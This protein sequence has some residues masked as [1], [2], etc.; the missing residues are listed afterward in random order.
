MAAGIVALAAFAALAGRSL[1]TPRVHPPLPSTVSEANE[2]FSRAMLFLGTQQDLP[3]A[4]QLLEKALALDPAFA[5]ARAWYGF[6]HVLLIDSGLSNDTSWL[7][8]AEAELRQALAD[9]PNSARA[10][11]SLAMVYLYQGRKEL[12]PQEARKAMELDPNER[13]GPGMLAMYHQWNGEYEQGQ[14]LLKALVAADP[15]FVP[16]RANVGE[17]LRQMGD[18]AGS[19]REQQKILEQDPNSMFALGFLALAHMTQGNIAGSHEALTKARALEPQN[20]QVQ[21]LWALQLALEGHRTEAL[22]AMTGDVLKYG[23]LIVVTSNI[24]EFY[25]VLDDK[26]KAL[27]W[28]DRAVRAGDERASWFERDPLLAN[29]RQEPR[30]REIVDGIRY[31]QE[32]RRGAHDAPPPGRVRASDV[33]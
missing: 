5:H 19:I 20:Y 4:R 25:A 16:A 15:L 22:Q 8:K 32:R 12:T 29:L 3:R 28:L 14:A 26:A 23:E 2:Y 9:D 24:A 18:P 7:Y 6:T 21:A 1:W 27:E 10:H 13:D 30:F 31:R 33:T 11:A 17:N